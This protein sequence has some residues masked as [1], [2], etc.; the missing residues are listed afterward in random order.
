MYRIEHGELYD[1][2]EERWMRD[3]REAR[4]QGI[5]QEL[6]ST[7]AGPAATTTPTSFTM[8]HLRQAYR[9]L[10]AYDQEVEYDEDMAGM[11]IDEAW[12]ALEGI[13]NTRG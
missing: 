3:A 6:L 7:L 2:I 13:K 11:T 9:A 8:E 4:A 5:E 10:G 1:K 12:K